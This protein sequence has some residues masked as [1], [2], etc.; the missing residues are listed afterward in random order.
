MTH[1]ADEF[2]QS[3]F[4]APVQADEYLLA[5]AP[6]AGALLKADNVKLTVEALK[7][8]K[9]R[10]NCGSW[11]DAR[12]VLPGEMLALRREGT[13]WVISKI[14]TAKLTHVNQGFTMTALLAEIRQAAHDIGTRFSQVEQVGKDELHTMV[15]KLRGLVSGMPGEVAGAAA[16]VEAKAQVAEGDVKEFTS[17]EVQTLIDQIR[18]V[19]ERAVAGLQN[20]ASVAVADLESQLAAKAAEVE[21]LEAKLAAAL[22]PAP[23]PAPAAVTSSAEPAQTEPAQTAQV[24]ATAAPAPVAPIPPVETAAAPAPASVAAE[25]APVAPAAL[26]DA[27]AP[28]AVA[29]APAPEPITQTA[30]TPAPSA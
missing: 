2:A 23:A 11:E 20:H 26:A 9:L 5:A 17:G 4:A 10:L 3:A 18:S 24:A 1:A 30:P 28:A 29:P 27:P 8:G 16:E 7:D 22:K 21:A 12:V 15:E 25:P 19:H 13:F 6:P 14:E